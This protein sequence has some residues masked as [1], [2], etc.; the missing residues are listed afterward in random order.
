MSKQADS[1]RARGL[2]VLRDMFPAMDAAEIERSLG[3][4][5]TYVI[6]YALG[7]VWSRNVLPVR[8]RSLTVLSILTTLSAWS[9]LATY[10][11]GALNLG[12]TEEE[13]EEVMV[14]LSGYAGFA[15]AIEALRVA[16]SVM[17][18]RNEH[19]APRSPAEPLT[20]A[21]RSA[22][23]K[24]VAKTVFAGQPAVPGGIDMGSFLMTAARFAYGEVWAR[25]HLSRR[26]RSLVVV[27]TLVTQGQ[28]DEAHIHMGAAMNHGLS[29]E[30][31]EELL[32]TVMTY[33]GFPLGVEGFKVLRTVR[34]D[35]GT[36]S[37][38]GAST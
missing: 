26:D 2:I 29:R 7:E 15:R 25:P 11:E 10:V 20:G 36:A 35:E 33:A 19:F 3:A 31:L 18:K 38:G 37:S 23:L 22:N 34:V 32:I 27:T 28:Y 9:E 1:S 17:R 5:G 14:Q 30:E 8:E 6:D 21:Q 13:I 12:L 4:L 24:S 16:H